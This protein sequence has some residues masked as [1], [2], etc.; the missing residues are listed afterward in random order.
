V[1][2]TTRAILQHDGRKKGKKDDK[3]K[4]VGCSSTRVALVIFKEK[5]KLLN[6]FET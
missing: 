6:H 4:E 5:V 2:D 1:F 3:T